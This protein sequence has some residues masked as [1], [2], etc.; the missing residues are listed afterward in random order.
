MWG[1]GVRTSCLLSP[2]S[3]TLLSQLSLIVTYNAHV[4]AGKDYNFTE[5]ESVYKPT[6]KC[7]F[8]LRYMYIFFL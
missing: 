3:R 8:A 7:L 6:H 2:A 1:Q 4:I 5:G